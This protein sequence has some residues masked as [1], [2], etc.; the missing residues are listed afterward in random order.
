MYLADCGTR[1]G[2]RVIG[3]SPEAVHPTAGA[4]PGTLRARGVVREVSS[5][6]S[7]TSSP[8]IWPSHAHG[9]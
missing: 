3:S 8:G 6:A 1:R 9:S 7:A 2:R 4:G 5:P